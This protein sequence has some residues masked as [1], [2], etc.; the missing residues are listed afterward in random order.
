MRRGRCEKEEH[1]DNL[2]RT[3]PRGK[4]KDGWEWRVPGSLRRFLFALS[5]APLSIL[6]SHSLSSLPTLQNRCE[7]ILRSEPDSSGTVELHLAS[8]DAM[9][10]QE[11]VKKLTTGGTVAV[12]AV[13]LVLG[14]AGMLLRKR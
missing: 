9:E 11:R 12:A 4:Q 1:E 2:G 3:R 8:V 5:Q 13:G 7:A 14:V 6:L 10:E